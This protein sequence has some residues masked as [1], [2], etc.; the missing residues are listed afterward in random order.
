[1]RNINSNEAWKA[2]LIVRYFSI[3][4]LWLGVLKSHSSG[5]LLQSILHCDLNGGK[6]QIHSIKT[7]E[8]FMKMKI[9]QKQMPMRSSGQHC[10]DECHR[11]SSRKWNERAT[12]EVRSS[13]W[14]LPVCVGGECRRRDSWDSPTYSRHKNL[15][16]VTWKCCLALFR[17]QKWN[18]SRLMNFIEG[19]SCCC[20]EE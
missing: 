17:R 9:L 15:I 13:C 10:H 16:Y 11:S 2:L 3:A 4:S 6:M 8:T 19:K 12:A 1:M 7:F 20:H 14:L 18:L 5:V